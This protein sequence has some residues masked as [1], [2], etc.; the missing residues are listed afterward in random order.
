M[1]SF[2]RF[3][4]VVEVIENIKGTE[5]GVLLNV[6]ISAPP[7]SYGDRVERG[8][9]WVIAGSAQEGIFIGHRTAQANQDR[10]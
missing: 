5:I 10:L 4:V 6:D 8:T 2:P 1:Y 7:C 9:E 3:F